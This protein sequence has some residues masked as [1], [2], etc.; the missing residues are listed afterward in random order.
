MYEV[1]TDFPVSGFLSSGRSSISVLVVEV[2]DSSS[3][4]PKSH[5]PPLVTEAFSP[6][7]PTESAPKPPSAMVRPTEAEVKK[8]LS[9]LPA[10]RK[11]A[12]N[13]AHL[14]TYRRLLKYSTLPD[15]WRF[16]S[17]RPQNPPLGHHRLFFEVTL[18]HRIADCVILVSGGHQPVCYVVELKTCLSHQLIPT[19]T[20]RTSQRAQ[21]LCQLSDSIH[22]IAHS[23]PP[24]T[25]A[26]TITPLLIFKNQKTLKTVYSESPGAFPT[27]VHT[28]EGKLCAFLTARENADIRKV[29]SKVPK[30]PKM[31]RGGKILGPTPGKRAVYSQAHHGRNKKGRP[32]TAQPTR[33]KSRTKDKGTPAFPRAGPACS[34]P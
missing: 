21:G 23:A 19:N 2:L 17:S 9:R 4:L 28:T 6:P 30:K 13:R 26:W 12:G 22:Y 18:G 15:L 1:F 32:W 31:D 27:P 33:A 5:L 3:E 11:R 10:A 14:A 8:S 29:L 20:V 34:G 16:L 24:G 7:R 25:E